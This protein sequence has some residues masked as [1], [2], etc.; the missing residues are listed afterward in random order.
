MRATPVL[1]IPLIALAV[2]ACGGTS[3][4]PG[5]PVAATVAAPSAGTTAVPAV[6]AAAPATTT[7]MPD[8]EWAFAPGVHLKGTANVGSLTDNGTSKT[9]TRLFVVDS[10]SEANHS[11][12]YIDGAW[13]LPVP[14]GGEPPEGLAWNGRRAVLA[15]TD[16]PSRFVTFPVGRDMSSTAAASHEI[17]LSKRGTFTFDTLSTDGN[18]LYL[19][20]SKDATGKRVDLIR[21]YDIARDE[22]LADPVVDKTGGTEAMSGTP[23]A[24]EFSADGN[25]VYTVYEGSEHPFVHALLTDNRI[26]VCI[27]LEGS[28]AP[29]ATGGWTIAWKDPSTL[30]VTSDRLKKRFQLQV[31]DNFP[32]LQ[33]TEA[34]GS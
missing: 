3:G 15:S 23:V 27:D 9:V 16:G 4:A 31:T 11:V 1:A 26:S 8:G 33:R 18:W 21:A 17:D 2:A 30:M 24:R 12:Q 25:G 34:L 6:T 29:T 20:Q 7:P 32:V 22:L 13:D 10:V 19:A 14:V 28:P 5:G